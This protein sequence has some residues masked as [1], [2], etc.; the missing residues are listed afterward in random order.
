[1]GDVMKALVRIVLGLVILVGV[2]AAGAYLLPR[3]VAVSR[4]VT[5]EAPPE[6]VFVHIN[7]L[8]AFHEWSPW[9]GRDPD[10]AVTFEG[11]ETGVGNKMSWQSDQPDVGNGVQEIIALKEN[12]SVETALDFGDMGTATAEWQL[13]AAGGGT[14]VTWGFKTDMGMN[15]IGRYMGLMMDSWVGGDYEAGLA[16]LK[17]AVEGG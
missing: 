17:A 2:A 1:M 14:E 15:P 6:D 7:S 12:E 5:I 11:P 9:A 3:E 10:M 8:Q 16:N 4:T 13:A